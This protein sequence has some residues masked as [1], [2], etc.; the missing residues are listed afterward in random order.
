MLDVFYG[1]FSPA[2]FALLGLWLVIVQIRLSEWQGSAL[3][4]RRS[5][6]V[7]LHFALPGIMSLLA[8]VNPQDSVFWRVSFAVVA[9]G[10]AIVLALVRGFPLR[11]VPAGE[12]RRGRGRRRTAPIV[13]AQPASPGRDSPV[14]A[15]RSAGFRRRIG[16]AAHRGHP[17]HPSPI[18]GLQR[19]VAAA[20][21]RAVSLARTAAGHGRMSRPQAG[22]LPADSV[23]GGGT[24]C[25]WWWQAPASWAVHVPTWRAGGAQ[26]TLIDAGRPG[27]ATAAGAGIICPWTSGADDP[28]GYAFACAATRAYPDLVA[29]L[30]GLGET[31]V[32]YRQ[33]GALVVAG[34]ADQLEQAWS[35]LRAQQDLY[36]EMGGVRVI[37]GPE[38]QR[39][40]PPLRSGMPAVHIP[41]AAR[42]DGRKFT[43]AR[44]G[45]RAGTGSRSGRSRPRWR[46]A[47][48]G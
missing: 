42:V 33:V 14:R 46:A 15:H 31:G 7:A 3:Q 41:G 27:Q 37:T 28:A 43:A 22:D 19:C 10:G 24:A 38:A 29:E 26:V 23:P 35:W 8:L 30:A 13:S 11:P 25:G 9:L 16:F 12:A 6:G 18:P 34:R 32:S 21:R 17:A 20:V 48:G 39:L 36:P 44:S 40:F 45:P 2:C 1:A 4:R 5:Y 47:T